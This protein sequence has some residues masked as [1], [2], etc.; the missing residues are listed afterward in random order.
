MRKSLS[1]SRVPV[2]ESRAVARVETE[3]C[4]VKELVM[5]VRFAEKLFKSMTKNNAGGER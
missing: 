3:G 4:S 5:F 2:T 1:T